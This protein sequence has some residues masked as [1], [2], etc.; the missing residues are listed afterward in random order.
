MERQGVS[1]NDSLCTVAGLK[2]YFV[3]HPH[4]ATYSLE[5]KANVAIAVGFD[6]A[7]VAQWLTSEQFKVI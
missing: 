7:I 3:N 6:R 1:H 2:A 5:Q 4:L